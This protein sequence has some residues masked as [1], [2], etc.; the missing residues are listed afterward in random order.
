MGS[1]CSAAGFSLA[2]QWVP[3]AL[4]TIY[5]TKKASDYP[6]IVSI[7]Q[8]MCG[9][10]EAFGRLWEEMRLVLEAADPPQKRLERRRA[11]AWGQ[12]GR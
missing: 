1:Y 10:P 7:S 8:E 12:I 9:K 11:G 6:H 2:P 3:K 5:N 4:P